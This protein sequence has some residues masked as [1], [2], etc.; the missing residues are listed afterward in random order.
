MC[1]FCVLST[2]QFFLFG[3][4]VRASRRCCALLHEEYAEEE[5]R[6]VLKREHR[7]AK[8]VVCEPCKGEASAEEV[9]LCSYAILFPGLKTS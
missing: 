5:D 6:C 7:C 9:V 4:G 8:C 3:V 1:V 2:K